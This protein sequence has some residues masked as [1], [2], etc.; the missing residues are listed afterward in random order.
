MT[1]LRDLVGAG[2]VDTE[3]WTGALATFTDLGAPQASDVR[4][5]LQALGDPEEA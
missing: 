5:Q 4:Q 2:R 1:L 3:A